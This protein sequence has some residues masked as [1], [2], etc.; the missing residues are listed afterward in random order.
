MGHDKALLPHPGGGS[1][2]EATLRLDEQHADAHCALAAFQAEVIDK[3]GA[4][5]GRLSYGAS[6]DSVAVTVIVRETLTITLTSPASGA[7]FCPGT[8]LQLA[9]FLCGIPSPAASKARPCCTLA[10]LHASSTPIQARRRDGEATGPFP[11][12]SSPRAGV[13]RAVRR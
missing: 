7:T 9:R 12:C 3:V 5:V 10:C 8:P 2:L 1:W 11:S 6:R 13:R 4:L